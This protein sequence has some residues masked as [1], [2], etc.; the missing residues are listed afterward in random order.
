VTL[1]DYLYYE[2]DGITLYCGDAREVLPLLAPVM[3]VVTDPPYGETSL[4]WDVPVEGW[5]PLV[6]SLLV[7]GGSMWVFGSLRSFM[8][9][10]LEGWRLA[11]DVVWEK[12]N[13]SGFHAD[14][15][16]R[17]HEIA[18]HFYPVDVA[19]SEITKSPVFTMDNKAR[20]VRKKGRPAHM[21]HI[22]AAPYVSFDGGPRLMRSVL[23]VRSTHGYAEHPTQKPT[24]IVRPLIEYSCPLMSTV[25][26]P[27]AGSGTTLIAAREA[28][29][30]A[31]GIEIEPRYCET[32][33]RRLRQG[34]L[35]LKET[36]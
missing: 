18:A 27:F 10:R 4:D 15:F 6:L 26:D 17:V 1:A 12:H 16:K 19:W 9:A 35:P 32:A 14:R 2:A 8:S 5:A 21:G 3:A 13:G 33:V 22:E 25:L 7:R 31:I 24:A 23:R 28:G 36:V 30:R 20:S 29:R 34:V 11:Q